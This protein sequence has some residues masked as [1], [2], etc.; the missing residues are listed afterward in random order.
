MNRRFL[1][2]TLT[3]LSLSLSSSAQIA[4]DFM[5]GGNADL[6]KTDNNKFLAK[7]QVGL[8]CNYFITR[9]FTGS[10]GF[11]I[12]ANDG[13][14]FAVGGRWFPVEEAFIR[15]RGLIGEND[16]TFGA[17]W[18]KPINQK[19]K[20]EAMGDFYFGGDFAIRAGIQYIIRR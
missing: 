16:F 6:I 12:W 2:L 4:G 13:V 5:A 8:E 19:I 14:S 15:F 7:A 1:L 17:G 18:T 9:Q 11:E 3:F 10:A 20:F